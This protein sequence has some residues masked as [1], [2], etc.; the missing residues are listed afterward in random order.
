MLRVHVILTLCL[1]RR[2]DDLAISP[3]HEYLIARLDT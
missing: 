3:T 2:A 1:K